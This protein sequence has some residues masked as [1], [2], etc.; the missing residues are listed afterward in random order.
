M[1]LALVIYVVH[2][3]DLFLLKHVSYWFVAQ[4][5]HIS[6][7][8]CIVKGCIVSA[9]FLCLCFFNLEMWK[10]TPKNK[11]YIKQ[12]KMKAMT[13]RLQIKYFKSLWLLFI[14][15]LQMYTS[16]GLP[17]EVCNHYDKMSAN[18]LILYI[19]RPAFV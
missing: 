13:S 9:L 18:I 15:F 7:T 1:W 10:T 16:V 6:N 2:L 8:Y 4:V 14:W 19:Y 5:L 12:H 11:S 3:I 17:Y